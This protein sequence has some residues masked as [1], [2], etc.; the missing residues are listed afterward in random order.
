MLLSLD[1]VAKFLFYVNTLDYQ[2]EPDYRHLKN[3]LGSVVRGGL[4]FS[5][6]QG[7]VG[8]SSTKDP[9]TREKVRT[10]TCEVAWKQLPPQTSFPLCIESLWTHLHSPVVTWLLIKM[11]AQSD[12]SIRSSLSQWVWLLDSWFDTSE[13]MMGFFLI[14]L[15]YFPSRL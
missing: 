8:E 4:E 10:Q 3:L 12:V 6:P 5:K 7:A 2:E 9:Q 13:L 14:S 15:N 1:E 11:F